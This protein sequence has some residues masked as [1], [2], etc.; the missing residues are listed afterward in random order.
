MWH[1]WHQASVEVLPGATFVTGERQ[2]LFS[3]QA[4]RSATF[5]QFYD[6]TPDNQRFV[7]IRDL[8]G[9][10][11]DELIVVENFFRGGLAVLLYGLRRKAQPLRP[12]DAADQGRGA[13]RL[14]GEGRHITTADGRIV[15]Y[16]VY[17]S[18]RPDSSRPSFQNFFE[19]LKAM[20]L[21]LGVIAIVAYGGIGLPQALL[22]QDQLDQQ[23]W[24]DYNPRWIRPS[25]VE[26]YGDV[27][28]RT[29]LGSTGW[30]RFV[31]R[32]SV[33]GPVGRFRLSGGVGTFYTLNDLGVNRLEFRPF[34][35]INWTWPSGRIPLDHYVRL[36]E[37][38]EFETRDWTLDASLRA[39]YRLQTEF[40][41]GAVPSGAGWRL[42]GHIEAF[43]TLIGDAGQFNER[44]RMGAGIERSLV[45]NARVRLDLTWQKV[46]TIFSRAP[47][48][49]LF[50]RLRVFQRWLW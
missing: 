31:L 37:R 11:A 26:L 5:H 35:G 47:S 3:V 43:V 41:W 22:A 20:V 48:D 34:Q 39:R 15:E 17:G 25:G 40:R 36:E 38:L 12:F 8:G 6:V 44:V 13:A 23:I 46:G 32:P 16:L 27:G 50:I 7:M 14:G 4:F 2:V 19:E 29:E 10:D 9:Q 21:A 24:I 30:G 1:Q 49:E 45:S 42:L 28:V 18:K 33:R